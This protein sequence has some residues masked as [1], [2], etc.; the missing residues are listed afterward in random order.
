MTD[1]NWATLDWC[2]QQNS[3]YYRGTD[4]VP[5]KVHEQLC[6]QQFRSMEMSLGVSGLPMPGATVFSIT[7]VADSGP[8]SAREPR[9]TEDL[10][11]NVTSG[12]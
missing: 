2:S 3:V 12:T 6:V 11:K 4:N 8:H 7:M 10:I 1:L 5:R 9:K